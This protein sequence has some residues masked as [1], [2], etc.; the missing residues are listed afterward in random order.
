MIDF[1][2]SEEQKMLQ[3]SAR[4][5]FETNLPKTL[6]RELLEDPKG[7]SPDIWRQMAEMGWMGLNLP[8]EY[9]GAGGSFLDLCV[10]VEELGRACLVDPFF[11]TV[12]LAAP[13]I[14]A[15]GSAEQKQNILPQ[16]A[17]GEMILTLAHTEDTPLYDPYFIQT[18]AK[19]EGDG[20]VIKGTKLFV[21]NAHVASYMVVVAR[22]GKGG[23]K[24]E[25]LSL[26]LVDSKA[27]GISCTLLK[28]LAR[29]QQYEVVFNNVKV[30]KGS[31]LGKLNEGGSY[32]KKVLDKAVVLKSVEMLGNAQKVVE[33]SVDY[34]KERIQFGRPIGSNQAIQW[35]CA[36]MSMEVKGAK[37]LLYRT[38][39]ELDQ[40][41]PCSFNIAATKAWISD[42]Q[43]RACIRAHEVCGAMGFTED[44]DLPVYT[45]RAKIQ[46]L[47]FG[48]GRYHREAVARELG[49]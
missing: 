27:H 30:P 29:D 31:L 33:I 5:F 22:T 45:R 16:V 4:E 14:L 28:T 3:S 36:D 41:L 37:Y 47:A 35:L 43:Y 25:G 21:E 38:A 46:E 20:Y 39:W 49:L 40:N 10:L 34:A 23:A 11:C 8:E 44:H 42:A 48:D 19:A 24:G 26:F 2:L 13:I 6:I 32:L 7:Y 17:S 9:D 12:A 1:D 15:V 18:E